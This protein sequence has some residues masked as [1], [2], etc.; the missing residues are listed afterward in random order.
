MKPPGRAGGSGM[1]DDNAPN[2]R[3]PGKSVQMTSI[4]T[5]SAAMVALRTLET[6]N[7]ALEETQKRISTGYRVAE[8]SDN[9]AYW[10]IATVMKSDKAALST[11]QD[12]LG[13]GTAKIDVTYTAL[14][15]A[16][17]VVDAIKSKLVAAREP[18]VDKQKIQDEINQ[19]QEQLI[20][21]AQSASFSGENWLN[22]DSS[23]SGYAATQEIVSSFNRTGSTVTVDTIKIDIS[24]LAL[25]DAGGAGLLEVETTS[26]TTPTDVTF[27][28]LSLDITAANVTDST[29]DDMIDFVHTAFTDLTNAASDLGAM[30]SRLDMQ[31]D[32]VATL[33]DAMTRGI[34]SLIDADM[35]EESTRLQALQTQQQLGVQSLSIANSSAQNI[36][37]L[38]KG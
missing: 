31:T 5:N 9:A 23:S 30:K 15:S 1:S 8:A 14:N 35:S 33:M 36:L 27:S 24:T 22:V 20:G 32:F 6:T 37:A 7:K 26:G 2:E 16:I 12:A 25:T 10:S 29:I 38:F 34:S 3:C 11:V 17:D 28:I 19:L 18:G 4:R 21:I 13:L